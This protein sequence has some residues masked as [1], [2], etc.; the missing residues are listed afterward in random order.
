MDTSPVN[1]KKISPESGDRQSRQFAPEKEQ[2]RETAAAPDIRL[3]TG[4]SQE[5]SLSSG[6]PTIAPPEPSAPPK[7]QLQQEIESVLAEDLEELYWAMA[8]PE[9][10]FFKQRGEEAASKIRVMLSETTLRIQAIFNLIVDWLKLLPGVSRF[11]VEQEAKIKT[12]KI[13]KFK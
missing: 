10:L 5:L 7:G 8:E 4:Q 9:R 6:P 2:A 12:D 13:I 11:F 1:D 3:K